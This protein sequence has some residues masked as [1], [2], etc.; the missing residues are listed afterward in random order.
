M[1]H[2]HTADHA[3]AAAIACHPA[4]SAACQNLAGTFNGTNDHLL[5]RDLS[6]GRLPAAGAGADRGVR[7]G[8]GAGPGTGDRHLPVRLDPGF[9]RWR[10]ALA[11]LVL[12]AA[13]LAAATGAVGV[14]VSWYY[15]PYFAPGSQALHL[16]EM[17]PFA[18][19]FTLRGVA[20]PAWTIAA[21]TIGA[22]AGML[23]RRVVPAIVAT[24]AVYA[25]LA[26]ATAG[27]LREHYL[28]PLLTSSP[29]PPGTAWTIS[30]WWTKDGRFA[31][32]SPLASST[33][34]ALPRQPGRAGTLRWNVRAVPGP[35]RLHAVDQLPAGQPVLAI[36]V[37]QGRLAARPV[38]A[39]R[40][41]NHLA[42][43]PSRRLTMA[44]STPG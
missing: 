21:F 36:P 34:S 6:R 35:A 38:S 44:G 5:G 20:F 42:G 27:L 2:R 3:Y 32:A 16:N 39:A 29:N 13:V 25:G 33:S 26:V 22:L 17:S 14:L 24:L 31:F 9:G 41:H 40:R 7:R 19:L 8:A 15:Q 30:Q 43:P 23:I 4:S 37:D 1:D 10:W 11:K 28:A 18:T 12:L